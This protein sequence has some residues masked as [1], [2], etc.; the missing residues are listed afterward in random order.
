MRT[1]RAFKT[2]LKVF[3]IIFTGLSL[4][5]IKQTFLEGET[6]TLSC[7][8]RLLYFRHYPNFLDIIPTFCIQFDN[9][10]VE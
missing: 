1:E 2:K 6:P 7:L 4:K 3:F 9:Y 8:K 5:Q 10:L